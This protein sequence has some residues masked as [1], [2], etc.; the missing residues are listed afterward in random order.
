MA[1]TS[2]PETSRATLFIGL[3]TLA[4][5]L[6]VVAIGLLVPR[7]EIVTIAPQVTGPVNGPVTIQIGAERRTDLDAEARVER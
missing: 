2:P 3:A 4:L 1:R 5:A 7:T 6:L